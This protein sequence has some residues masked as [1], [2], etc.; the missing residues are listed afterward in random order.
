ME[1]VSSV[2]GKLQAV[3][4]ALKAP[5][6]QQGRFGAHRSAESIL[7][8]VKP[9]LNEHG[10]ILTMSDDIVSVGNRNY[11]KATATVL[12]AAGQLSA[13]A[14]AWEGEV[15]RGLDAS[16]VTGMASSYARKYALG[17]LFAIDDTKDADSHDYEGKSAPKKERPGTAGHATDAQRKEVFRILTLR[18]YESLEAQKEKIKSMGETTPLTVAAA[19]RVLDK[20]KGVES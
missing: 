14:L 7:A 20:L 12:D 8:A 5:K 3:Q 17:G 2:H 18:G 15:S 13:S 19:G 6:D 10:L 9:L 16:Q 11:I 4:H 1:E